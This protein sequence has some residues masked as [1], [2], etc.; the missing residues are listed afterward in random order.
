MPI[1]DTKTVFPNKGLDR[2]NKLELT[3]RGISIYR[4]VKVVSAPG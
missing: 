1:W 3:R 2:I 4:I